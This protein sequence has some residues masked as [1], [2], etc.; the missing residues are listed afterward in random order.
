MVTGA[1]MSFIS[2]LIQRHEG[3]RGQPYR[4]T[5]GL[6]TVGYGFNLKAA[7]AASAC[8][9]CG[10]DY[11][12]VCAEGL[13]EAQALSVFQYQLTAVLCQ[14]ARTFPTWATMPE[15][16]QAVICDMLFMGEGTFLTFH[17]FIAAI[18][19]ADWKGAAAD[20]EQSLWFKE[21]GTRGVEDVAILR[22]A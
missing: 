11:A 8:A 14:A 12:T 15:K 22:A 21:V 9:S 20:L 18:K 5:K 13:T 6:L 7:G 4:D 2:D 1:E 19:A 10:L 17:H 3:F 16:V